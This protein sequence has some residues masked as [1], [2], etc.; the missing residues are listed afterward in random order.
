MTVVLVAATLHVLWNS[1][2]K[3]APDGYLATV[4]IAIGGAAICAVAL[5]FLPPIHPAAWWNI[6]GSVVAQSIYYPCVAAAYRAADLSLA[7]P[8]MRG[9]AP[10]LVALVSAPIL[11]ESL[12]GSQWAG[13]ALICSGIWLMGFAAALSA[14]RRRTSVAAVDG[15]SGRPR[16]TARGIAIAL[17]T[18]AIIATYTIIDGAGVRV[19]G[20][21]A[22]YTAWIFLFTAVPVG[23]IA[24]ITRGSE[25]GHELRHRW[26]S[27]VIGGAANV[28]A[29]GLVLWAMTKAPVAA[30]AAL[31]ETSILFATVVAAL[32]FK[33][34]ISAGRAAATLLIVAGAVVLRLG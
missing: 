12:T 9:T 15:R 4:G 27:M 26:W 14:A 24:L 6:A 34:K 21:P 29:Y 30:V 19:S 32:F 31:R 2:V 8:L 3:A 28:G 18:A 10:M 5:A 13:V 11:A 16:R 1:L 33:E 17:G 23:V 20:A 7:Y 25:V 22:T